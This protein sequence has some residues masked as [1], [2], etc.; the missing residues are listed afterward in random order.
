L[1]SRGGVLT[2]ALGCA[3]GTYDVYISGLLMDRRQANNFLVLAKSK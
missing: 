3:L 1:I 2:A